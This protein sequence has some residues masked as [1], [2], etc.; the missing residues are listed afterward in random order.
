[1]SI[2]VSEYELEESKD[3]F[4]DMFENKGKLARILPAELLERYKKTYYK[5]REMRREGKLP[6][7]QDYLNGSELATNIYKKKYYLKNIDGRHIEF[8]PEDVFL[9]IASFVSSVE[10][11]EKDAEKWA[12]A[13]YIDLFNMRYVKERIE[14]EKNRMIRQ[15]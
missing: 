4:A 5:L 6:V 10:K 8:K 9:R 13:F 1:M 7:H 2:V 12:V 3:H 15:P 14:K 11:N